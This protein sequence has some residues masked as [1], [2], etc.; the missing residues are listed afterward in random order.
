MQDSQ[1]DNVGNIK[2]SR[3]IQDLV[4][5]IEYETEINIL[6][7]LD[8]CC[9][10]DILYEENYEMSTDPVGLGV[11]LGIELLNRKRLA[12]SLAI[13]ASTFIYG[14]MAGCDEPIVNYYFIGT[15]DQ[16]LARIKEAMERVNETK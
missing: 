10:G 5:E 15:E 12:G 9:D 2:E 16:V 1:G 4:F 6:E 13:A 7:L 14:F 3:A 8:S 11:K